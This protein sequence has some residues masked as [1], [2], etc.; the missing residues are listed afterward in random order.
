M[1]AG[2]RPKL[3][4]IAFRMRLPIPREYV[5]SH[6]R[7]TSKPLVLEE[8]GFPRDSMAIEPGSPT[9]ARDAYYKYVFDLV[10]G[11][12]GLNGVNFWAWGGNVTPPHSTWESGDPYTGDPAQEDQGLNSV[13]MAD[14][15]TIALIRSTA[16]AVKKQKK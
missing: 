16:A 15:S 13:F 14:S 7:L 8:F 11:E 10:E 6:R 5:E 1:G 12:S 3:S 2:C 9:T 4:P